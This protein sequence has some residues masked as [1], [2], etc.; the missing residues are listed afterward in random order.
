MS[1]KVGEWFASQTADGRGYILWRQ[2][3]T[4][5]A[6]MGL[7]YNEPTASELVERLNEPSIADIRATAS[8]LFKA[9]FGD[10]A[11]AVLE[12]VL[13]KAKEKK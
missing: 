3:P 5:P 4:G 2:G 9:A 11:Q 12:E 10:L 6:R 7:I 8:P 13:T 1:K